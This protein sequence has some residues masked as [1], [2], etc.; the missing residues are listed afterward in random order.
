MPQAIVADL[1]KPLRQ[2]VR[3]EPTHELHARQAT[4]PPLAGLTI[5]VPER[6]MG[7]VHA[8]NPRVGDRDSENVTA[9]VPQD[10]VSAVAV[11]FAVRAPCLLPRLSWQR[12]KHVRFLLGQGIPESGG[13]DLEEALTGLDKRA[14]GRPR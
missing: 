10:G 4:G 6:D 2:D 13:D 9:Q 3:Q 7:V 11:V 12:A 14:S 8:E 1:V 5:L